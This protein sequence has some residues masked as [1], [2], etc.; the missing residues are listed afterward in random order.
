MERIAPRRS[1]PDL[2]LTQLRDGILEG[3]LPPGTRLKL[4]ATL[5]RLPS[6]RTQVHSRVSSSAPSPASVSAWVSTAGPEGTPSSVALA[7]SSSVSWKRVG[8]QRPTTSWAR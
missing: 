1:V 6:R 7:S 3:R 8:S 2:V 5:T 4:D